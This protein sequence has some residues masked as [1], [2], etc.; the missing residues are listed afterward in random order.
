VLFPVVFALPDAALAQR[1]TTK[2]AAALKAATLCNDTS[3]TITANST[4]SSSIASEAAAQEDSSAELQ[5]SGSQM[6]AAADEAQVGHQ[7]APTGLCPVVGFSSFVGQLSFKVIL[8]L[9]VFGGEWTANSRDAQHVL[10]WSTIEGGTCAGPLHDT[11]HDALQSGTYYSYV[12]EAGL[13]KNLFCRVTAEKV[14][15]SEG[16]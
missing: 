15:L 7:A 13:L 10:V 3:I 6:G 2:P 11:I 9:A 5:D 8:H 4:S 12:A 1:Q 16:R 14:F